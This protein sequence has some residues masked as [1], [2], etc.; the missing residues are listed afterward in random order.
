MCNV[1]YGETL[2]ETAG[3]RLAVIE[4]RGSIPLGSTNATKTKGIHLDA[5]SY[6]MR[7]VIARLEIDEE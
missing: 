7:A 5:F 2:R 4:V 1:R 6:F 3:F